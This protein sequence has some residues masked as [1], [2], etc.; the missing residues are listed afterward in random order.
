MKV[1]EIWITKIEVSNP[2]YRIVIQSISYD[3]TERESYITYVVYPDDAQIM[4]SNSEGRELV[5]NIINDFC[6]SVSRPRFLTLF[7][8]Y[9]GKK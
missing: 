4:R 5:L 6:H 9:R 8:M 3:E 7:E 1:G 2:Q